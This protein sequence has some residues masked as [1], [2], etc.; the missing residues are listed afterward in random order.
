MTEIYYDIIDST[1]TE[2]RRCA[3]GFSE[4][5]YLFIAGEQTAGRGQ[6]T[7]TFESPAGNGVYATLLI[8]KKGISAVCLTALT[9]LAA[10]CATEA[11]EE[12]TG[13]GERLSVK[14]VN[15]LM[16]DGKK[17][18]GILAAAE[19]FGTEGEIDF[20]RIGYGINTGNIDLT[21]R[22]G[23][24][25]GTLGLTSPESTRKL[26]V[27]VARRICENMD[28]MKIDELL[29]AYSSLCRMEGKKVVLPDGRICRAV[30]LN[31]DFS[32]RVADGAGDFSDLTSTTGVVIE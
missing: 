18:G 24:P 28:K 2:A 4:G 14:W 19:I 9:P 27:D 21:E 8:K 20:V 32:L 6:G 3:P 1:F 12:M 13:Y 30:G 5:E 16:L 22:I 15:D 26:A 17:Y 10:V 25:V 11:V 31:P 23:I 7:H 29:G